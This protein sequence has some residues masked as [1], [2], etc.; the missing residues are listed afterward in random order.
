MIGTMA[1]A[2]VMW[3]VSSLFGSGG[4]RI[5]SGTAPVVIVTVVDEENYS[6]AYIKMVKENRI[7]Y[8]RKHGKLIWI[9]PGVNTGRGES[10]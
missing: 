4:E 1:F 2:V 7:E 9:V 6:P 5:P 8:A 10:S 3:I